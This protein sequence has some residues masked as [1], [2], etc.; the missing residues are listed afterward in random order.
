[1]ITNEIV[2][3]ACSQVGEYSDETMTEEFQRFFREQPALCEFV[4][5]LTHESGQRIQELSLFLSYMIFKAVQLSGGN[6]ALVTREA[7]ETAYRASEAWIDRMS[8]AEGQELQATLAASF[9]KDTEPYL[10]QYVISELSQPLEDGS[11]LDDNDKGEVF[12]LLKTVITS[13]SNKENTIGF[14]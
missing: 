5:E 6:V 8:E 4:V 1:M 14:E 11:E 7:L 9:N 10:L 3:K 13:L 12:F 2:E